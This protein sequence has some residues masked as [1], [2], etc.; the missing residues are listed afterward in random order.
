MLALKPVCCEVQS[1]SRCVE[2]A[3]KLVVVEELD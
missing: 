3:A 1:I 2:R